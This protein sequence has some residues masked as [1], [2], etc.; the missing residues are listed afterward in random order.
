[1]GFKGGREGLTG[2]D[3]GGDVFQLCGELG[4]FLDLAQHFERAQDR[5]SGADE[6][7]ELLIENEEGL[8]L[9]LALRESA[10]AG[11]GTD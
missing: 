2:F 3:A 11:A 4:V 9:Y 8:E 10:K 1:M 7:E 6:G 5:Q